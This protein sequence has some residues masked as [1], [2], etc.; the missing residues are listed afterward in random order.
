MVFGSLIEKPHIIACS[1]FCALDLVFKDVI[2]QLRQLPGVIAHV[3][4]VRA[5][6]QYSHLGLNDL[7]Q[8]LPRELISLSS[9]LYRQTIALVNVYSPTA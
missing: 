5:V 4:F 1:A 8:V 3:I 7:R 9:V 6:G 2:V